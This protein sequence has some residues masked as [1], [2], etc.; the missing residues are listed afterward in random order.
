MSRR[1]RQAVLVGVTSIGISTLASPA[2]AVSQSERAVESPGGTA[3]AAGDQIATDRPPQAQLPAPSATVTPA[4]QQPAPVSPLFATRSE[5]LP[6]FLI[7]GYAVTSL[8]VSDRSA[9]SGSTFF[10]GSFN[11]A[12]FARYKDL[13][14]VESEL[15]I[16][17]TEDGGTEVELEFAQLDLLLHNN[18]ILV[19]GKFLSPI[20]QFT[21]RLHPAWI[22]RLAD[23]PAGFSHGGLQPGA[24]VG[25]QLRGGVMMGRSRL[26]YA[27]A[28]GNGPRLMAD[29][30]I[31]QPGFG[32]DDNGN[33]AISGRIAF[34]PVPYF[35]VGGS[36]QTAQ[37]RGT[38]V[39]GPI[40]ASVASAAASSGEPQAQG[41]NTG[42]GL[43][44]LD[45]SYKRGPWDIRA[46]FLRGIRNAYQL[47]PQMEE[48][49]PITVPRMK[50]TAWYAQLAYRLSGLT[51]HRILQNFEPVV[52]YGE[53]TID[54]FQ[55]LAEES[56]EKRWDVGMNYWLGPAFVIHGAVQMRNFT[57]RA[58]A[59]RKDTRF[60]FNIGYGF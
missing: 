50:L 23:A 5:S 10:S 41:P 42:F 16:S 49:E 60:L 35:E 24:E 30:E 53:Y 11:P 20:G 51:Q 48:E 26:S 3:G 9:G 6:N 58:L 56:Q 54:G 59:E 19:V 22:N 25:A 28:V 8:A 13:L 21:E 46:E 18:L 34:L 27:V 40:M 43:W 52:R 55:T 47:P 12:L 37:V 15:G 17:A 44:G 38:L 29:G 32:G 14:L 4:E 39:Q 45:A 7:A 2:L 33:K 1:I 57:A 36:F 31:T